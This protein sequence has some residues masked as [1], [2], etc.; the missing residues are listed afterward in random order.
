MKT[1]DEIEGMLPLSAA[2]LLDPAEEREIREHLR[3]CAGCTKRLEELGVISAGLRSLP[4]PIPPPYLTAR[5]TLAMSEYADRRESLQLAAVS[6][7]LAWL[8]A[9][10]TWYGLRVLTGGTGMFWLLLWSFTPALTAA[11]VIAGLLR[12]QRR[13]S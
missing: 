7:L 2:G 13:S 3:D 6:S 9:L 8:L 5:T 11:P 10:A 12:R 4:A 1:H